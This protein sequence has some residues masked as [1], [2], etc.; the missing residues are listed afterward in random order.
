MTTHHTQVARF[1]L[2]LF[3]GW[4]VALCFAPVASASQELAQQKNCMTCHG[5]SNRVLGPSFKEI[6]AKHAREAGA[7]DALVK[8]V[9]QG[10]SGVWGGPAMPANTQLSEADARKLVRWILSLK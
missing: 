7:E 8:K 10:T 3:V 1:S 9:T 2:S 4:V 6:S 5:I